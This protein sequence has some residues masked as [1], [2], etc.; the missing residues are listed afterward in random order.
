MWDVAGHRRSGVTVGQT[1]HAGKG[2][3]LLC[4]NLERWSRNPV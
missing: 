2:L 4:I 1:M 3:V